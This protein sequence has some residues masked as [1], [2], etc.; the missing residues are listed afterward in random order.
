[1][2][3]IGVKAPLPVVEGSGCVG[4]KE[5]ERFPQKAAA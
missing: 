3:E 5:V 2:T 1:M 4:I